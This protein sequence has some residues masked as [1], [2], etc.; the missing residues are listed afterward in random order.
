MQKK[1]KERKKHHKTQPVHC[2]DPRYTAMHT[3][4]SL[5]PLL[6][7]YTLQLMTACLQPLQERGS[8]CIYRLRYCTCRG[9]PCII[10]V[11]NQLSLQ[12][13]KK[14]K[15]THVYHPSQ[16]SK[17]SPGDLRR[18]QHLLTDL[19][20]CLFLDFDLQSDS[21]WLIATEAKLEHSLALRFINS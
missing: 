8:M 13:K 15:K 11:K 7:T 10:I 5:E 18:V 19:K 20:R 6:M 17:F 21:A 3:L 4:P 9:G 1:K 12:D 2:K 16:I 14:R